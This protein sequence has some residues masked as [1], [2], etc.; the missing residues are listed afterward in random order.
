MVRPKV[1]SVQLHLTTKV[2][3][4]KFY[5]SCIVSLLKGNPENFGNLSL[6]GHTVI[7]F[8]GLRYT[9]ELR[10]TYL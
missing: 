4:I 1:D 7:D 6:L 5:P 8:S 3:K 10:D 9:T 2:F